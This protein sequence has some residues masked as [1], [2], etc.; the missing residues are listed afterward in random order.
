MSHIDALKGGKGETT[1]V[2]DELSKMCQSVHGLVPT[3]WIQPM[4]PEKMRKK[5]VD[6]GRIVE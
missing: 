1:W 4:K 6:N 5:D 3:S 2:Q